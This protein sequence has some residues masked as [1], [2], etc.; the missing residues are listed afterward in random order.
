MGTNYHRPIDPIKVM[1][2]DHN[3]ITDD[4]PFPIKQSE[5]PE[6]LNAMIYGKTLEWYEH[7]NKTA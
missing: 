4:N 5:S 1:D 3:P 7:T 6:N 2:S